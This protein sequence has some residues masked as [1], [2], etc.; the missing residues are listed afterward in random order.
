MDKYLTVIIDWILA[1]VSLAVI[2]CLERQCLLGDPCDLLVKHPIEVK[3]KCAVLHLSFKTVLLVQLK[4][5]CDLVGSVGIVMEQVS[6][7]F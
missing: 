2:A 5:V 6:V 4:V 7:N 1:L 3:V